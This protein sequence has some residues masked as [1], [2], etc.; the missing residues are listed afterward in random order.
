MIAGGPFL[1][2]HQAMRVFAAGG[3][4]RSMTLE[5]RWPGGRRSW[6]TGV[7][8]NRLYEID[9]AQAKAEPP[10]APAPPSPWFEEVSGFAPP[11]VDEEF[12]DLARQPLL[13]FPL[14]GLGPGVAWTDLDGDG[15]DD[16]VIG[17]GQGGMPAA[18]R[19]DG[20]GRLVPLAG[21]LWSRPVIR[22]QT[23]VVAAEGM[24]IFGSANYE[25]GGT[26]GGWIRIYD[27]AR[28]VSGDSVLG[29]TSSTGPLALADVD[30]DG[31]LDL[32][33]GGRVVAGRYPEPADSLLLRND[34]GRLVPLVRWDKLG[35]VSGAV[36]SDLDRDGWPDLVLA[37]EWGPIRVFRNESGTAFRE[38][39]ADWGLDRYTGW[40]R[41]VATGDFDGDGRPDIVAS[42]WGLNSRYRASPEVPERL[43]YG[44][45]D[46]D[47]VVE[48]IETRP[49]PATGTE[50]PTRGLRMVGIA[51]PW[52]RDQIGG[53][54]ET[55][56]KS[57]L[58]QLYGRALQSLP[59]L[60]ATT[61]AS[62]VFLNRGDRF[63]ARPLPEEAQWSA[64][65]AVCVGDF[66]GDGRED[67]FL[68]QN[69]FGM[70][71]DGVR[72]DSGLGL[73]LRGDGRGGFQAV[74]VLESGVRV[75]GGQRGAAL[76]DY[77]GDGRVDLVVAQNSQP[78]KLF[79]NARARPGLRVRLEG[80]PG[81]RSALGAELR[82]RFGDRLGP[83]REVQGGS[84]YNSQN[85]PV[86]VLAT[87]EAATHLEIRWPTGERTASPL[88]AGAREVIV[89]P[90][91]ELRVLH[92][93]R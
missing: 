93:A 48:L 67:V 22:D 80:A 54:Y 23:G 53:S 9:E 44:D 19:N 72:Q 1:S 35:L 63:E 90:R 25:D 5:V 64:A 50:F 45:L 2:G 37:C 82:V 11:H 86:Q 61:L 34:Q 77:D 76:A 92:T 70:P 85:S 30:L 60:E 3:S 20:R 91:G 87:S 7:R 39:T 12:D 26:N 16:L 52:L 38:T 66:D 51:L 74:S 17:S 49:D 58:A 10:P 14:S 27:L 33:V 47:Y 71:P 40:W 18:F 78:A 28:Q 32:F 29:P 36:F 41:G 75:Y 56:G 4:D 73:W 8:A 55:Y 84:G 59:R 15:W 43:Y 83:L 31:R 81:N 57:S 62:M 69:F 24:V 46:G 65:F 89:N 88:P 13:M 79:R 6:L 42:N 21:P 68:S